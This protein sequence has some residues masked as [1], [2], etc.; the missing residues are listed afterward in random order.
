M[1][2]SLKRMLTEFESGVLTGLDEGGRPYSLRCLVEWGGE[3]RP[4][5][6]TLPMEIALRPGPASLLFHRHNEQL[7]GLKSLMLRGRL[8]T[9]GNGWKFQIDQVV[10]GAGNGGVLGLVRF[11]REGRHTAAR[12][13]AKRNMAR[14]PIPWDDWTRIGV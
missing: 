14:P 13:L 3:D 4:L 6:L 11:V 8:E 1:G 7:S 2:I 10:P 12:Y 5:G 9:E